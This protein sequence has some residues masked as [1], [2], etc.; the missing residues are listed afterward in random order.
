MKRLATL[1]VG[2]ALVLSIPSTALAASSTCQAYNNQTCTDVTPT[3]TTGTVQA[4]STG[5]LPFTGIDVVLLIAGAG[6][7]IGAGLV[8]RR[9]SNHVG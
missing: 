6:V 7:L 4:T 2:V 8:V 9:L 1:L 3:T 5:S